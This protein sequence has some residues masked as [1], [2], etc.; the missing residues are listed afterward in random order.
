M[1]LGVKEIMLAM[2]QEYLTAE[3]VARLTHKHVHTVY[4]WIKSD[5]LKATRTGEQRQ[6]PFLIRKTDL[7]AFLKADR[8]AQDQQH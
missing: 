4:R 7:D 3:E 5:Q 2:E 8:E 6:G 1:S